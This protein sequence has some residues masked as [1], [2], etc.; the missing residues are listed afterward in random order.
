MLP[1]I[2]I[3]DYPFAMYYLMALFGILFV[4]IV[5][6]IKRKAFDLRKRDILGL[7]VFATIGAMVGA[8]L[9][10]IIGQIYKHGGEPN[11]WTAENWLR[12]ASAGGVFFG[13]LFGA[14]GMAVLFAKIARIELKNVFNIAAYAGLA[15]QS[16]GRL[17]CYCA[18]C[19]YGIEL[20][21][22]THFPIQL[23]EAGFCFVAL[24]AYLIIR[25]ERR[26]PNTPLFPVYLITY[27]VGRF[28]FEFLRGDAN[29]GVWIL[30]TS[31]WIA[32]GLFALAIVWLIKS[33]SKRN[34]S[35][36]QPSLAQEKTE[37]TI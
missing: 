9:F 33:K 37:I 4:I 12:I 23:V 15:F 3:D 7:V 31:Q 21:D 6:L 29:R 20:A 27:S 34:S 11:F 17:G 35:I 26:W 2:Y 18:G 24:L 30:S 13:G 28:A 22:G 5:G 25:P 36:I 10:T 19:C 14:I 1:F 8:K 32:L 16:L